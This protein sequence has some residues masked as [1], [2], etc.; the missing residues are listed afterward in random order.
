MFIYN[1]FAAKHALF[2]VKS[3]KKR[4]GYKMCDIKS[5]KIFSNARK[6]NIFFRQNNWP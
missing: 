6:I 1:T 5:T 4:L 3:H 2:I